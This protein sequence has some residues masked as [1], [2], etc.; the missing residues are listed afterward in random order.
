MNNGG[1]KDQYLRLCGI[2]CHGLITFGVSGSGRLKLLLLLDCRLC[3]SNTNW[4]TVMFFLWKFPIG[5][6]FFFRIS[7]LSAL[8]WNNDNE[9]WVCVGRDGSTGFPPFVVGCG[10]LGGCLVVSQCITACLTSDWR[11]NL[12]L[13]PRPL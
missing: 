2:A 4:T 12:Q 10:W 13:T 1:E 11:H 6:A 8:D 3:S 7:L 9:S 5:L